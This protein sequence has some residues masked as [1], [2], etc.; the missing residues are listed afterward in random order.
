MNAA[1]ASPQIIPDPLTQLDDLADS[2]A[3]DP[4]CRALVAVLISAAENQGIVLSTDLSPSHEHAR[5]AKGRA[6]RGS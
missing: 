5:P 4:L 6:D 2:G 1:P 3:L